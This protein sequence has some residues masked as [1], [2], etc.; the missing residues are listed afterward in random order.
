MNRLALLLLLLVPFLLLS[1]PA[2]ADEGWVITSFDAAYQINQDGSVD[3][4]EDI[5]VDFGAQQKHGILRDIPVDYEYDADQDGRTDSTRR[6]QIQ[7]SGITD[8]QRS[9]QYVASIHGAVLNLRIGDPDVEVSG[10]QRYVISYRIV[11]M[12]NAQTDP[13]ESP[14]EWD[15]FYWNVNGNNAPVRTLSA[16]AEV[17]A[18]E[19]LKV[20]CFQGPTGSTEECESTFSDRRANFSLT[21]AQPE[22]AGLTIVVGMPKGTVEVPPPDLVG[23]KSFGEEFSDFVGLKPLPI[24]AAVLAGIVSIAGVLRYWWLAGRDRWLG[25]L[26]YLSGD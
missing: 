24:L 21:D 23:T 9:V 5:R 1:Q 26:Q 20:E 10:P 6:I 25:D 14:S 12:L 18:P 15:E 7:V 11:G 16:T 8:G 4:V 19:I 17:R 22:K 2:E 3:V 13:Q